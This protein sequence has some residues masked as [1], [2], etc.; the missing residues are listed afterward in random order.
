ML[1]GQRNIKLDMFQ[2]G[3]LCPTFFNPYGISPRTPQVSVEALLYIF[4]YVV[5]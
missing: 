3:T 1:H 5:K 2:F 4:S